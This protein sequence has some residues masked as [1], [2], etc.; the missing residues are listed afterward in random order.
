MKSVYWIWLEMST[1]WGILNKEQAT[2][3][4]KTL[5]LAIKKLKTKTLTGVK[6]QTD[7]LTRATLLAERT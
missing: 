6:T 1:T 5:S 3:S 4:Y 2:P 7:R